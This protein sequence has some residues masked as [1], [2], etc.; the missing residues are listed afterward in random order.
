M[1]Q[2]LSGR[3]A[4]VTGAGSGLGA[5]VARILAQ[6]GAATLLVARQIAGIDSVAREINAAGG[7]AAAFACDIARPARVGEL[8]TR[9]LEKFG[10]IDC[11]VNSAGTVD[12]IGKPLW[13]LTDTEWQTLADTNLSGPLF[14]CRAVI[15]VMLQQG[16]G[17]ILML[18]STSADMPT[19]TA[20]AYG[21]TKAA[22]NQMIRALAAELDGSGVVA[23]VFNPGPVA[24]PTLEKVQTHLQAGPWRGMW[25]GLAQSPENAAKLVLWL[26]SPAIEGVT[27]QAF[28]WRDPAVQG[29]VG[30][31]MEMIK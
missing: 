26:C 31:M 9:A 25:S 30:E 1:M 18:T 6:A 20:G 28:H 5:G 23:N 22:V 2:F 12:G 27:G 19:P 21:A 7:T 15:P 10:R 29:A 3:V 8:V 24:T 4:I 17:R 14:L 11:L 16:S 13:D